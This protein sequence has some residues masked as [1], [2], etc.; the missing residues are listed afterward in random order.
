MDW[1][2]AV[3]RRQKLRRREFFLSLVVMYALWFGLFGVAWFAWAKV[4]D[5]APHPNLALT[6][7]LALGGS[8]VSAFVRYGPALPFKGKAPEEVA[9]E[10]FLAGKDVRYDDGQYEPDLKA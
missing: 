1:R 3:R 9:A 6:V 7:F 2:Q 8:L 5:A 4:F 10:A